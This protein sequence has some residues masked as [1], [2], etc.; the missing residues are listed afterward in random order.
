MQTYVALLRAVNVGGTGV[1]KMA[2][3]RARCEKLGFG[4]VRTHIQT[5]NVILRSDRT[6][7]QVGRLIEDDLGHDA[8]VLTAAQLRKAA[9]ANPFD[10][11]ADP[12]LQCVLVFL[13]AA[14]AA[15]KR[16][17]LMEAEAE[18]YR[19]AVK[20]AVFYYAY[21]K[22]NAAGRK[23]I[24]FEKLLGLRGTGRS[25]KVVDKLIELA[26]DA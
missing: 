4:D 9:A 2:D 15:A 24:N 3:L 26:S 19:C 17:A 21:A 14:P 8:F 12:D 18:P 6:A 5:G 7:E 11:A 16:R 1:I 13:S 20:G 23:T 10:V 22:A 25:S